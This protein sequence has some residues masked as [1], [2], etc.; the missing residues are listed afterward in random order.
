MNDKT[1]KHDGP[2]I[3]LVAEFSGALDAWPEHLCIERNADDTITLSSRSRAIIADISH[4]TDDDGEVILPEAINGQ[5]VFGHDSE[6]VVGEDLI[7]IDDEAEITLAVGEEAEA[8][9][10][11][12]ERGWDKKAGYKDAWE[13]IAAA[14]SARNR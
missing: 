3:L 8:K 7:P 11:L 10:W 5:R 12:A 6:Y 14:L 4:Y 9:T 1:E 2:E 13:R